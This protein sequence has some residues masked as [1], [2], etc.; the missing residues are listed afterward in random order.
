MK[1]NRRDINIELLRIFACI[2]VV[3]IHM[4]PLSMNNG[5]VDKAALMIASVIATDAVAIFFGITGCFWFLGKKP[6]ISVILKFIKNVMLP[7]IIA[8]LLIMTFQKY[9]MSNSLA[10]NIKLL[11]FPNMKNFIL[12]LTTRDVYNYWGEACGPYWYVMSYALLLFWYPLARI[13]CKGNHDKIVIGIIIVSCIDCL[14][15]DLH[16]LGYAQHISEFSFIPQ[17]LVEVLIGYLLYKYRKKFMGIPWIVGSIAL[18]VLTIAIRYFAQLRMFKLNNQDNLTIL[19]YDH[20]SAYI[21]M[22]CIFILV[23]NI[24]LH[25]IWEWLQYAIIKIANLTYYVYLVHYAVRI[26]LCVLRIVDYVRV[27]VSDIS[28]WLLQQCVYTVIVVMMVFMISLVLAIILKYIVK[29]VNL[30]LKGLVG[31][32]RTC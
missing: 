19:G 9:L 21:M 17:S 3:V 10:C 26:K 16:L 30:I 15:I 23:F 13:L 24:N 4:S 11:D 18:G 27:V 5:E 1:K 6:F 31:N 28:N 12:G 29:F 20:T 7:A 22:I 14:L 25:N 2:G 8:A 32:M